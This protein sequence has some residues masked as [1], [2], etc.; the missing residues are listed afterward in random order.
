MKLIENDYQLVVS[1]S[2]Q[3]SSTNMALSVCLS[4]LVLVSY[5][6]VCYAEAFSGV[7]NTDRRQVMFPYTEL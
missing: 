4:L 6:F 5:G 3:S 7:S 1:G 2:L